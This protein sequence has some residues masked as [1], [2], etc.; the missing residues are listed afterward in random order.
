MDIQNNMLSPLNALNEKN[1]PEKG[2]NLIGFEGK[3][4]GEHLT[5]VKKVT[6]K[7][8]STESKKTK[9]AFVFDD[10][11]LSVYDVMN[12]FESKNVKAGFAITTK[13]LAEGD[14]DKINRVGVCDIVRRGHEVLNHSTTHLNMS[15]ETSTA[16]A[17]AEIK[18]AYQELIYLGADVNGYVAAN[19]VLSSVAKKVS[20]ENHSYSFS[21]YWDNNVENALIYPWSD[22]HDLARANI[23]TDLE[24][25]AKTAIDSAIEKSAS[26]VMYAHDINSTKLAQLSAVIDYAIANNVE[27]VTPAEMLNI[28]KSKKQIGNSYSLNFDN[29]S[30]STF[31]MSKGLND[32]NATTS[33]ID[34]GQTFHF[35]FPVYDRY[36]KLTLSITL[37]AISGG[38]DISIGAHCIDSSGNLIEGHSAETDK[39]RL[40]GTAKNRRYSVD[41][42]TTSTTAKIRFFVRVDPYTTPLNIW[43]VRPHASESGCI[44]N[45]KKQQ[46]A[47]PYTYSRKTLP[48]QS[49]DVV[50]GQTTILPFNLGVIEGGYYKVDGER[51]TLLVDGTIRFGVNIRGTSFPSDLIG[52]IFADSSLQ[53]NES[54]NSAAG[55]VVANENALRGNAQFV[56]SGQ[57]G[58]YFDLSVALNT[59]TTTTVTTGGDLSQFEAQLI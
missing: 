22:L 20:A 35:E 39:F 42:A 38:A 46:V 27:I 3:S 7:A 36:K 29:V 16:G 45:I 26:I 2:A 54:Y 43:C 12:L 59:S 48:I 4:V 13:Y 34:S 44:L 23:D 33:S 5:D 18:T 9:V 1:D 11:L 31:S 24:N 25:Q 28:A 19:S 37:D 40:A 51:V 14:A 58:D 8:P 55:L 21:R 15:S 50:S 32:F 52:E 41:I 47:K 53:V 57:R 10:G 30:S 17:A 56:F 49:W 6:D